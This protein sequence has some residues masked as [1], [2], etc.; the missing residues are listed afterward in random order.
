LRFVAYS[1]TRSRDSEKSPFVP[2]LES[3]RVFPNGPCVKP[4]QGT[5]E[6]FKP[7]LR[8]PAFGE[9]FKDNALAQAFVDGIRNG[10]LHE[11]ETRKWVIWRD[12]PV[13]LLVVNEQD[14][15]ALNRTLFYDVIKKDFESYLQELRE[16][17]NSA[18]W[19]RF[20]KKMNDTFKEA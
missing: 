7:F 14:G 6:Q 2:L 8:R 9:A 15:F 18:M 1:S 12:E 11:A 20:K 3:G 5:S 19:Q 4:L 13:G 17:S 10:I 16:H